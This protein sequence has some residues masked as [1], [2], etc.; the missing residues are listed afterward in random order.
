MRQVGWEWGMCP[1][2]GGG[3]FYNDLYGEAPPERGTFF[4]LQVYERVREICHSGLWNGP[5]GRTNE[6]YGF[7]KSGKR[8]IFVIDSY[9][10]SNAFRAAK[11]DAN[12]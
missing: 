8:S 11:R 9:L 7:T 3:T 10:N 1:K 6:F 4:R 5:K 12:F 2:G